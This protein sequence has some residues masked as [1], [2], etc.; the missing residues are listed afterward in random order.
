VSTRAASNRAAEGMAL[1]Q[2]RADVDRIATVSEDGWNHSSHYYPQLLR[3]L[4][5]RVDR[6]LEVGCGTGAFTRVLAARSREVVALDLSPEMIRVARMRSNGV[7]NICFEVGDV[8]EWPAPASGSTPSPIATLHHLPFERALARVA[9]L[10]RPGGT[11]FVLEVVKSREPREWMQA[12]VALPVSKLMLLAHGRSL[13]APRAVSD[14]WAQHERNDHVPS[15]RQLRDAS[16][17]ALPG[18]HVRRHLFWRFS[19]VWTRPA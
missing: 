15:A 17:R 1:D 12:A 9:G 7:A 13:R 5:P 18:A 2:V 6:A 8:I 16:R 3:W 4:P 11:L 14:A 10:L 19:I